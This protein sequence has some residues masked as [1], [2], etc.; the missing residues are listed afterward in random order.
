[1]KQGEK[2]WTLTVDGKAVDMVSPVDGRVVA[3]N[4]NAARALTDDPY[5]QGWLLKIESPKMGVN[6]KNLL[7]GLLAKVWTEQ[8]VD[9]LFARANTQLGAVAADGGAPMS[10]MAKN[11]DAEHWDEIAREFFLTNE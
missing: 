1:V 9:A 5:G 4:P 7:T 10:G 6:W 11:I 3:V 8:S 2:A